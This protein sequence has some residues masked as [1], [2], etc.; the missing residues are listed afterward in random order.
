MTDTDISDIKSTIRR[1]RNTVKELSENK[2]TANYDTYIV[3]EPIKKLTYDDEFG[4]YVAAEDIENSIKDIVMQ[5]DYDHIF[6]II[7]LGNEEYKTD[8]KI[9]DW[10]GLRING[11]LWNRI[12]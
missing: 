4:Y 1:F 3:K 8:I 6:V 5:N 9:N 7:R 12:L 10:I 11:L 2:M